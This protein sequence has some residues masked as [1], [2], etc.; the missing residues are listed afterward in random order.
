MCA[1]KR[2]NPEV[3][4]YTVRCVRHR[5]DGPSRTVPVLGETRDVNYKQRHERLEPHLRLVPSYRGVSVVSSFT[6]THSGDVP[7]HVCVMCTSTSHRRPVY[8]DRETPDGS[9]GGERLS[10][11]NS[12]ESDRRHSLLRYEYRSHTERSSHDDSFLLVPGTRIWRPVLLSDGD[13][14][15]EGM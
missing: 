3:L 9:I 1:S 2:R 7:R 6:T 14:K 11:T 13:E 5:R 8:S 12:L 4:H 10:G 15:D